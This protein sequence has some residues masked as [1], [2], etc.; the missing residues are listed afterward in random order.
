MYNI[1]SGVEKVPD[2]LTQWPRPVIM[3]PG[4]REWFY[5]I[6]TCS[7]NGVHGVELLPLA[8]WSCCHGDCDHRGMISDEY[9]RV[10]HYRICCRRPTRNIYFCTIYKL[11]AMLRGIHG[12]K[13][14]RP[15]H[16]NWP[17][18]QIDLANQPN[19]YLASHDLHYSLKSDLVLLLTA[20][21]W[22]NPP[23]KLQSATRPFLLKTDLWLA[24]VVK[25]WYTIQIGVLNND[26]RFVVLC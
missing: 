5:L 20:D 13:S 14:N 25:Y 26:L 3:G 2:C 7:V 12:L 17:F 21:S 18:W 19:S 24:M 15:N 1:L 6:S 11:C 23:L 9:H 8:L 10:G 22:A 4:W 16:A